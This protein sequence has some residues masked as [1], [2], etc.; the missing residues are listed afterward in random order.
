MEEIVNIHKYTLTDILTLT[1][2]S[3]TYAH[4]IIVFIH[5]MV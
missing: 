2:P 5:T 1:V 4:A 3:V